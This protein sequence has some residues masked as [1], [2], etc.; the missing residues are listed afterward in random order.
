[1]FVYMEIQELYHLFLEKENVSTDTRNI[2]KDSIFFALKGENFNANQFA[3]QALDNGASYVVVDDKNVVKSSK[4]ILVDDVLTTLQNLA[5]H[6]RKQFKIPVIGITGS[7]GKTTTKE[8]IY[9]VL[10]K[11]YNTLATQGNLNNHIGVP[12]TLLSLKKDTEIAII[13]MGAN[14]IGEIEFLSNIAE[15]NFGIITNIGKA[16]IEGFGSYQGVVQTK[17]ELYKFIKQSEGFLFVN[18]DDELLMDLSSEINRIGYGE[19]AKNHDFKL[20]ESSPNLKIAWDNNIITTNLYGKYN[21]PNIMAAIC[22]GNYFNVDEQ[23]IIDAITNYISTNNRSQFAKIAGNTYYL[24]AYN[25]NP[26]SMNAAVDTFIE[27]KFSNKLMILGDMLE[28]GNISYEEHLNII[29]KALNNQLETI[30]VGN[31][32]F[33]LSDKYKTVKQLHFFKNHEEVISW[34]SNN[35]PKN[36]NIL[37]K[38]SRGIKLE[39]IIEA[40]KV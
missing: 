14:H 13:E 40:Q 25:A 30:F 29:E 11:K 20:V 27:G 33:E 17:S 16:H 22:I 39:K 4:F 26:T 1:M 19:N 38:G 9:T 6:H 34:F 32:F 24:D 23:D 10:S 12:L 31:N 8:L 36:K 15:P 5:N 28:L 21:F 18:E 2:I 35:Q 37:V 7:N 3:Q